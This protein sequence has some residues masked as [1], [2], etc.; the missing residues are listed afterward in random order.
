MKLYGGLVDP[1][2][3]K[4]KEIVLLRNPAKIRHQIRTQNFSNFLLKKVVQKSPRPSRRENCISRGVRGY[5]FTVVPLPNVTP[6]TSRTPRE[7]QFSL[8]EGQGDFCTNFFSK[9]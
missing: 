8:R 7:M 3:L 4:T 6:H 5:V 2:A 9:K 1:M